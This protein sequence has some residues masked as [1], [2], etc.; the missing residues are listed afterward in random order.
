MQE[1][2]FDRRWQWPLLRIGRSDGNR[3][4]LMTRALLQYRRNL[5]GVLKTDGRHKKAMEA[6]K[7][8]EQA[9]LRLLTGKTFSC[10]A[11]HLRQ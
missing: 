10:R 1:E 2:R 7:L 11:C 9:E 6:L 3:G 5:G 8:A 4:E